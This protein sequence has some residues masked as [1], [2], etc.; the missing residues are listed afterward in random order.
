MLRS[1]C[2]V[3]QNFEMAVGS[4]RSTPGSENRKRIEEI[5]IDFHDLLSMLAT[6]LDCQLVQVFVVVPVPFVSREQDGCSRLFWIWILIWLKMVASLLMWLFMTCD[7]NYGRDLR[8]PLRVH[9]RGLLRV[10]FILLILI[11]LTSSSASHP[12]PAGH[13]H[14]HQHPPFCGVVSSSSSSSSSPFSFR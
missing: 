14:S 2:G 12:H 9:Y 11:I 6:K 4:G 8:V 5:S 10:R 13:P 3:C 7:V 1:S